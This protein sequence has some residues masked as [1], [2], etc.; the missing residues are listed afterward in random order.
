[1]FFTLLS[2][3][4]IVK[5]DYHY[6]NQ[7]YRHHHH[8]HY[9]HQHFQCG[10]QHRHHH[11][12]RRHHDYNKPFKPE[13]HPILLS[14]FILNWIHIS[15]LVLEHHTVHI[16]FKSLSEPEVLDR[17]RF[18]RRDIKLIWTGGIQMKSRFDHRRYNRNWSNW[19]FLARKKF[20]GFNGIRIHS[21][22][23]SAVLH[24]LLSYEDPYVEFIFT[25]TGVRR[26]IKY[27]STAFLY[28]KLT[29]FYISFLSRVKMNSIKW[30]APN[31]WVFKALLIKHCRANRE[32]IGSNP[33]EICNCF[34]CDYNRVDH[35]SI[36]SVFLQYKLTSFHVSLLSRMYVKMVEHCSAN[37]EAMGSNL[38]E[39]LKFFFGLK[40]KLQ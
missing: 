24:Y 34:N 18:N 9:W 40:K 30:P 1:M 31:I 3:V 14:T 22:C 6:H 33:F 16:E 20:Q 12:F 13:K 32:A 29:S 25:V 15:L 28:F 35:I 23:V 17:G 36:S 39:A 38:I 7:H 8:H 19:N 21:L 2:L 4:V 10:L 27:V 37:A 11:P 5:H 26:E